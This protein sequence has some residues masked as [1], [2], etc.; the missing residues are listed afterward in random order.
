[1]KE[2]ILKVENLGISFSQYTKGLVRTDLEVIKNLDIDEGE[3]KKITLKTLSDSNLVYSDLKD[4][5]D[6]YVIIT[7]EEDLSSD[8]YELVYNAYIKCGRKYM[9]ANYS[10]Y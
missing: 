6:G 1:M 3:E 5:C 9:T 2:Q 4:K 8:K 10:E 7:N